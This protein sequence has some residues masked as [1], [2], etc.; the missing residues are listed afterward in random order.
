MTASPMRSR[1]SPE[2]ACAP[3]SCCWRATTPPSRTAPSLSDDEVFETFKAEF[4]AEE[5][6]PEPKPEQEPKEATG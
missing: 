1:R 5:V 4:D 2:S 6:E 3:S